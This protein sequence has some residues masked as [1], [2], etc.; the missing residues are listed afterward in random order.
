MDD[1]P[2][3]LFHFTGR[4][5]ACEGLNVSFE[6][7]IGP[8]L[9]LAVEGFLD[10]KVAIRC[11]LNPWSQQP[12]NVTACGQDPFSGIDRISEGHGLLQNEKS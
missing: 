8:A 6:L 11:S 5:R 3:S 1:H 7:D 4:Q 12:R 9:R 2:I 10:E